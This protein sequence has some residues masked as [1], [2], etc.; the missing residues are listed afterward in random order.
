MR[1]AQQHRLD[2]AMTK[3]TTSLSASRDWRTHQHRPDGLDGAMT[4]PT[5]LAR[6]LM[7]LGASL[8]GAVPCGPLGVAAEAVTDL[9]VLICRSEFAAASSGDVLAAWR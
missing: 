7:R 5:A 9:L 3:P 2:G 4:K 1:L 6:S 8:D